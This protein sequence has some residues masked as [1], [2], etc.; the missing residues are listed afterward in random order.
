MLYDTRPEMM[1]IWESPAD[2]MW[3]S[4][5]AYRLGDGCKVLSLA[6]QSV[7]NRGHASRK[8]DESTCMKSWCTLLLILLQSIA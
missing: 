1:H 2:I 5:R 8:Y 4:A 3:A 7:G 6:C